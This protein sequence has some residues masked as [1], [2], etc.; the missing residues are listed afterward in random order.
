MYFH[1][2]NNAPCS[3]QPDEIR[4]YLSHKNPKD[5]GRIYLERRA[6]I[7]Q[8][9]IR[10][11][12]GPNANI[13]NAATALLELNGPKQPPAYFYN[14]HAD[15]DWDRL[16]LP[17]KVERIGTQIAKS[18]QSPDKK[19]GPFDRKRRYMVD[20]LLYSRIFEWGD[21]QIQTPQD[22]LAYFNKLLEGVGFQ[23]LYLFRSDDLLVQL[24]ILL[25][26]SYQEYLGHLHSS[27]KEVMDEDH[28]S[29]AA[30]SNI[31][32]G[33]AEA[34]LY[35]IT[36]EGDATDAPCGINDKEI[37]AWSFA[38]RFKKEFG[39]TRVSA[40]YALHSLMGHRDGIVE[41]LEAHTGLKTTKITEKMLTQ[42][43]SAYMM[44]QNAI[45][46]NLAKVTLTRARCLARNC[47]LEAKE[48]YLRICPGQPVPDPVDLALWMKGNQALREFVIERWI[49]CKNHKSNSEMFILYYNNFEEKVRN[50]NPESKKDID[51]A[52]FAYIDDI[53]FPK[54]Q[55]SNADKNVAKQEYDPQH[56]VLPEGHTIKCEVFLH[57]EDVSNEDILSLLTFNLTADQLISFL[58]P[59]PLFG[60]DPIETAHAVVQKMDE[61]LTALDMPPLHADSSRT[62][63]LLLSALYNGV[64]Y[65]A[66][67]NEQHDKDFYPLKDYVFHQILSPSEAETEA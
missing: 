48:E 55:P 1:P 20:L 56:N 39:R 34:F 18:A 31:F 66:L 9:V 57:E 40:Y 46:R 7:G 42:K 15:T 35:R 8:S 53:Y 24:A 60:Y 16:A 10:H 47:Y 38:N 6:A 52:F 41:N 62:A 58:P 37:T 25:N 28:S 26:W 61:L 5:W 45:I 49:C 21:P 32:T 44:G 30:K 59:E 43:E 12:G 63:F 13:K 19:Q 54:A 2:K 14:A 65:N 3:A 51:K 50:L 27:L 36:E 4:N 23:P 67:V 64:D 22:R 29:E 17:S 33:H 11:F